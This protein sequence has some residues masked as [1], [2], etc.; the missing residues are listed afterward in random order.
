MCGC[1]SSLSAVWDAVEAM[2]TA[3]LE[4]EVVAVIRRMTHDA[5]KTDATVYRTRTLLRSV[6]SVTIRRRTRPL[7]PIAPAVRKGPGRADIPSRRRC[8]VLYVEAMATVR[9]SLGMACFVSVLGPPVAS[10][11]ARSDIGAAYDAGA[12]AV[13]EGG[14]Q[15]HDGTTTPAAGGGS[16]SDPTPADSGGKLP[17][18]AWTTLPASDGSPPDTSALSACVDAGFVS[19]MDSGSLASFAV[20]VNCVQETPLACPNAAWEYTPAPGPTY[21]VEIRNTGPVPIAYI[22]RPLWNYGGHYIP[23]VATGDGMELVGVLAPSEQVNTTS[24]YNGGA[25]ALLGSAKPFSVPGVRTISDEGAIP[26]PV[27]ISGGGGTTVMQVAEIQVSDHC[28]QPY[29]D[30]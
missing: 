16:E 14:E 29:Q 1:S 5:S 26:W 12:T 25:I 17:E 6:S 22:A 10:C 24:V 13:D 18:D 3:L 23:G 19:K 20:I 30:W 4:L 8:V 11:G 27:G 2:V 9:A 15:L 28:V 21:S 7:Q